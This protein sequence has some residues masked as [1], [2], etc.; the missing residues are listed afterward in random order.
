MKFRLDRSPFQRDSDV[1]EAI[2]V[3]SGCVELDACQLPNKSHCVCVRACRLRH[4][5]QPD[6]DFKS[7]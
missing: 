7:V 6:D 4:A 3:S 5:V 1:N 2:S